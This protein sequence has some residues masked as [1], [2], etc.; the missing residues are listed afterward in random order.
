MSSKSLA[1]LATFLLAIS[2]W[3]IMDSRWMLVGA[4]AGQEEQVARLLVRPIDRI[5]SALA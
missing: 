2:P 3:H 5:G 4:R 1:L